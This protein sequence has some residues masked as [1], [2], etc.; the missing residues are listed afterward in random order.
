MI[1]NRLKLKEGMIENV[2]TFVL[3]RNLIY[4]DKNTRG[5]STYVRLLFYALGYSIP[6]MKGLNYNNI[7]T[8]I[9]FTEKGK[10]YVAN[11]N[12]DLLVLHFEGEQITYNLPDQHISFLSFVFQYDNIKVLKNLLGFM[13]VD[14]DKGWTLLNRG[15]VI[16][17]IKFSI[18]E[19]IAGLYGVDIDD[20][21]EEKKRLTYNKNK[22]TA[23]LNLQELSDQVDEENNR[24]LGSDEENELN[25][26]IAFCNQKIR[27]EKRVLKE[28]ERVINQEESF[29][30][31]IDSMNL[32]V[33]QE[34]V[35]IP[36]NRQTL[37]GVVDHS[38]YLRARRSIVV[39]NLYNLESERTKY[40]SRLN[41]ITIPKDQ[42]DLLADD[43]S[44]TIDK[45][46]YDFHVDQEEVERCLDKSRRELT[47][48]N[49]EIKKKL[50]DNNFYISKIYNYVSKYAHQLGVDDKI[51]NKE[52][53]IFTSDLK[54]LSGAVLQK[55][56]FAFKIAFLKV[57]EENM[58]TKLFIVLDSPKGK[59]LDDDNMKLIEDLI[60]TELSKNQ[61]FLASIYKLEHEKKIEIRTNAIEN[62]NN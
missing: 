45:Q 53:F 54:S 20:L 59:E 47:S 60:R 26:K 46:I 62:R 50:K 40:N 49:A 56:V 2:D 23:I 61:V 33:Q 7:S 8:E 4:S 52:D 37:V 34:D 15:T 51:V 12:D 57:I 39:T 9:E 28:I 16:G 17:K 44:A 31:Y 6:Q 22:Y 42:L 10:V 14:Q 55:M 48:I 25:K 27:N 11:R 43:Q 36:V 30:D 29:F 41:E 13:Y 1:I 3:G 38:E 19:L 35:T 32:V 21:I 24:I 18:E 5:K 58:N